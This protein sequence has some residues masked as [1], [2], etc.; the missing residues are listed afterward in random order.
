MKIQAVAFLLIF[1][2]LNAKALSSFELHNINEAH[3]QGFSGRGVNLAIFDTTFNQ[4]HEILASQYLEAPMNNHYAWTERLYHGSHIAGIAAGAKTDG[5]NYGIASGAKFLAYGNLGSTTSNADFNKIFTHNVKIINNSHDIFHQRFVNYA[6]QG[7]LIIYANANDSAL[8]PSNAAMHGA[9]SADNAGAWLSVGNVNSQYI[10]RENGQLSVSGRAITNNNGGNLCFGASLYCLMAAG[11]DILSASNESATS[12]IQSTGTSQA[13]PVVSGIAALVAEK[14]PFLDGKQLADVLTSTANKDFKA[15]KMLAIRGGGGDKDYI[16]YIDTPIPKKADGSVD[17]AQIQADIRA[18]YDYLNVSLNNVIQ[19]TKEQ[20]FGQGIVDATK[21]LKGLASIDINRLGDLDVDTYAGKDYAFYTLDTKGYNAL[22]ENDIAQKS[23]DNAYHNANIASLI[24]DKMS[25]LDAGLVKTGAGVLGISGDLKFLGASVVREG[26]LSLR[27]ATNKANLSVA[28]DIFVEQKGILSTDT[29]VNISGNLS[30]NGIFNIGTNSTNL[31]SVNGTYTQ[32]QNAT[33]T[34]SFLVDR[35]LNSALKANAYDIQGGTLIYKPLSAGV[36]NR[37]L[38]LNLQ[39]LDNSLGKF[40]QI[41]L[42]TSGYALK[43]ILGEDNKSLIVSAVSENIYADFE[44]A[45]E[46]LAR[47]LRQMSMADINS[48]YQSFFASLNAMDFNA[49][50]ATLQS[51]D[52]TVHLK[53]N[54]QILLAQSA[55]TLANVLHLQ[56]TKTEWLFKP[57]YNAINSK[58]TSANR[59]GV[60]IYA[61]KFNF[62]GVFSAF[63]HYDTLLSKASQKANSQS[64]SVGASVKNEIKSRGGRGFEIFGGASLGGAINSLKTESNTS[65]NAFLASAFVGVDK[66]FWLKGT[67]LTPTA[68]ASYNL[69]Y[70]GKIDEDKA[71][72]ARQISPFNSHFVSA[73]AGLNV[74]QNISSSLNAGAYGFYERRILGKEFQNEAEFKDFAGKFTQTK[75]LSTDLARLGLNLNYE[76]KRTQRRFVRN[77]RRISGAKN[78]RTMQTF[79]TTRYFIS[80]GLESEISLNDDEYKSFGGSLRVGVN[81]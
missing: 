78:L 53:Q 76:K 24:G 66:P 79:Y 72:F 34:L 57:R 10:T 52:D 14:Y 54:E 40:T 2:A 69:F 49:Y 29:N 39:G 3:A 4:N 30:N 19:A 6:K 13:A 26:E 64:I 75:A 11:T 9:G 33:L 23:W 20:V 74:S 18:E 56:S 36:S 12:Y 41:M 7:I 47:I 50:K 81:F 31:V 62:F 17:E 65:Y 55:N 44:G 38:T 71:L 27:K 1:F 21:A 70:Q 43:Y 80:L 42:D 58:E 67:K 73:N 5:A 15:P 8:N 35:G 37:T 77:A 48:A 63:L 46:S 32:G 61:N 22:F 59:V 51:L 45:N 25:K 68:F 28:G 16:I 60:S